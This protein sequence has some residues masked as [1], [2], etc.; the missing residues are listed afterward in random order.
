[1]D[2][3]IQ[4]NPYV[5]KENPNEDKLSNTLTGEKLLCGEK[6]IELISFLR[7]PKDLSA[8]EEK[9]EDKF[10]LQ[11]IKLKILSPL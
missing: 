10:Y 3:K 11:K 4:A 7:E 2:T 8:I 9:F 6:I 1:M 5:V